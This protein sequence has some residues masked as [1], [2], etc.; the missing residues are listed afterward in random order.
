MN[1]INDKIIKELQK[2]E[3]AIRAIARKYNVNVDRVRYYHYKLNDP[4]KFKNRFVDKVLRW[5]NKKK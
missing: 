3:L 2:G 4:E 5:R 1:D